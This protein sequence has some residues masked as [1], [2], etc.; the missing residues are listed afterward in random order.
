[1]RRQYGIEL[2]KIILGHCHVETTEI[3]AEAD[4]GYAM[5][6]MGKIG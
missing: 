4:R 2:A 5:E 1:L 3:Y 6:V